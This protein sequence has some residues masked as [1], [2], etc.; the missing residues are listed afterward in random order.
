MKV[1]LQKM[2]DNNRKPHLLLVLLTDQLGSFS[3][4]ICLWSLL[5]S[6]ISKQHKASRDVCYAEKD[7]VPKPSLYK[8][9][10]DSL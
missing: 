1:N 7:Y 6:S 9:N 2:N 3:V 10:E 5:E 4:Y 8:G